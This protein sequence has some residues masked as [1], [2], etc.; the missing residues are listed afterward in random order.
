MDSLEVTHGFMVGTG[1]APPRCRLTG[2]H[3]LHALSVP[4]VMS[5]SPQRKISLWIVL[6]TPLRFSSQWQ[7]KLICQGSNTTPST[8]LECADILPEPS[9]MTSEIRGQYLSLIQERKSKDRLT[10]SSTEFLKMVACGSPT[11]ELHGM[12]VGKSD[13]CIPTEELLNRCG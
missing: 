8:D 6:Q 4:S 11:S 13:L 10:L 7:P 9:L 3:R 12:V 1:I 2:N 5:I